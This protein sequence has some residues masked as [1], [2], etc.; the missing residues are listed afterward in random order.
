MIETT[1]SLSLRISPIKELTGK[2]SAPGQSRSPFQ[3]L[4]SQELSSAAPLDTIVLNF[5]IKTFQSIFSASPLGDPF[6]PFPSL[7]FFPD[8]PSR[9]MSWPVKPSPRGDDPPAAVSSNS[10]EVDKI[11]HQA[12]GEFGIDP[13]LIKAVI[14]VESNGNPKAVSPA[15]AQ[16]L[17]QL[18]PKTAA[19]LGVTDPFDPV[20]NIR[21]GTRY[22][23]QLHNR[24][25]GDLKLMLAA[26]NWGMGNLEK[27]PE[28][29]P[30][31]TR[32]YIL[33]VEKKYLAYAGPSSIA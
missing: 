26:Y 13:A 22:L 18:M 4:V 28:M 5:L 16:G 6:S 12:A 29:L 31:E 20:Q 30:R 14:S 23:S 33:Q 10:Q 2:P 25:Q 1:P 32:N 24:Y 3:D 17:M 19:E 7:P 21:A 9:A 11:I 15:G 8:G 27:K